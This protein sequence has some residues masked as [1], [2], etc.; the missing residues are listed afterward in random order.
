MEFTGYEIGGYDED[1]SVH[2]HYNGTKPKVPLLLHREARDA[3]TNIFQ[4]H[5]LGH[6]ILAAFK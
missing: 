5:P 1:A 3:M 6:L 2:L 4:I